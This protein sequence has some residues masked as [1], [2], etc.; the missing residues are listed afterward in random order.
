MAEV[1]TASETSWHAP[2]Y[3]GDA[4]HARNYHRALPVVATTL[5][6]LRRFGADGPVWHRFGRRGWHTLD[7]ALAD[8]DGDELLRAEQAADQARQER[9]QERQKAERERRRPTCTRCKAPFSDERVGRARPGRLGRRRAV[10]RLPPAHSRPEGPGGGRARASRRRS[11]GRR[12]EAARLLVAP[13]LT[14]PHPGRA[15]DLRRG[16]SAPLLICTGEFRPGAGEFRSGAVVSLAAAAGEFRAPTGEFRVSVQVRAGENG[17]QLSRPG[18][19][20][21]RRDGGAGRACGMTTPFIRRPRR[22]RRP[23][24]PTPAAPA[25]PVRAGWWWCR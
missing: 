11:R 21:V 5:P 2:A 16:V 15:A 6:L 14:A 20:Q 22:P 1:E 17:R 9:E 3:G 23:A 13:L 25:S 4:V 7:Q 8:P 19:G 18:G 10:R 12:G 24:A